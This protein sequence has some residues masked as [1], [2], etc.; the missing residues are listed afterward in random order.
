MVLMSAHQPASWRIRHA[1]ACNLSPLPPIGKYRTLY[2][3]A[4]L[5][6]KSHFKSDW[7]P[8]FHYEIHSRFHAY[9]PSCLPLNQHPL[10]NIYSA[11][12]LSANP[13]FISSGSVVPGAP[14]LLSSSSV[15]GVYRGIAPCHCHSFS[16]PRLFL[17]SYMCAFVCVGRISLFELSALWQWAAIF[18]FMM[19]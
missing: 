14:V 2:S 6:W 9:A 7:G 16:R 8:L 10:L 1:P 19:M 17:Y 5:V 18:S 3:E 12:C 11:P 13:F 15:T 4:P